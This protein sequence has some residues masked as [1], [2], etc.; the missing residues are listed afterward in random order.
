[1]K[2]FTH[3]HRYQSG[4]KEW[5]AWDED[6]FGDSPRG[7]GQTEEE[8]VEDLTEQLEERYRLSCGLN[9]EDKPNK[10]KELQ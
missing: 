9:Y 1:V 7:V 2:I 8:A 10:Q 4:F 3:F 6:Y 5:K